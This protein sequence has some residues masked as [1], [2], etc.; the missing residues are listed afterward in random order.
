[1][2]KKKQYAVHRTIEIRVKAFTHEWTVVDRTLDD[3]E[4]ELCTKPCAIGW[5]HYP[6]TMTRE[7]AFESLK[8]C[9]IKRHREEIGKLQESLNKLIDLELPKPKRKRKCTSRTVR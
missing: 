3:L 2:T 4:R 8:N 9:M 6:I 5:Y 1:M 7:K